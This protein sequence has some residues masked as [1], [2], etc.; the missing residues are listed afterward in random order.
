MNKIQGEDDC[1]MLSDITREEELL[2]KNSDLDRAMIH[3]STE[4]KG[5]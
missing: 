4:V 1:D 2:K 3:A 5:S